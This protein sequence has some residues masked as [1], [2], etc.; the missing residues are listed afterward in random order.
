MTVLVL[1]HAE[2]EDNISEQFCVLSKCMKFSFSGCFWVVFLSFLMLGISLSDFA[3]LRWRKCSSELVFISSPIVMGSHRAI[4]ESQYKPE[5]EEDECRIG[6]LPDRVGICSGHG[7]DC[8]GV[9]ERTMPSTRTSES[10]KDR[11]VV[12]MQYVKGTRNKTFDCIITVSL[13]WRR[14]QHRG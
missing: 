12:T 14:R 4:L 8:L 9:I 5:T 13:S 1:S 3:F 11:Q 10:P 2:N 7:C 6:P